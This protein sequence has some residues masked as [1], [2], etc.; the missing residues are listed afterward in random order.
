MG[1]HAP[2]PAVNAWLVVL[3]LSNSRS[4]PSVSAGRAYGRHPA[5]RDDQ[6]GAKYLS[7]ISDRGYSIVVA[8]GWHYLLVYTSVRSR[9]S[10][11]LP[12]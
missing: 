10:K 7:E 9:M 4:S 6:S 1:N 2:H 3:M 8:S 11:G 12:S 5:F